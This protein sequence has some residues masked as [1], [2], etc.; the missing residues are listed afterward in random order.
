M[1]YTFLPEQN[2]I[3]IATLVC[4]ELCYGM[5]LFE[6]QKNFKNGLPPT[7]IASLTQKYWRAYLHSEICVQC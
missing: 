7:L 2:I 3:H 6:F 5:Y 1:T 4:V